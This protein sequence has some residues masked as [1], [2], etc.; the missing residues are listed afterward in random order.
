MH[1]TKNLILEKAMRVGYGARGF[2]YLVIGGLAIFTAFNGGEAEGSTG[3]LNYLVRQPFGSVLVGA[4]ALGLF[5]YALWRFIDAALDLEDEGDDANGLGNRFGQFLSG[6]THA[7]LGVTALTIMI[8]GAQSESDSASNW[9]AAIMSAPFGRW[10]VASA[11]A[12]T[13]GVAVYLFFKAWRASYRAQI[14]CAPTTR[15]LAPLIRFGLAAHGVVLLI[16][17]GMIAYAGWTTDPQHAIGLGEALKIVE[18]RPFGR[19]LLGI[20]GAGMACF[21]IYC[22]VQAGY[23]IA[24]NITHGDIPT[25][26]S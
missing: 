25:L 20:T 22:F 7:F 6:A 12:V 5:S 16:I 15:R 21:S 26:D 2:V 23:R 9:S 24:P 3:A 10:L 11:G 18:T 14:R 4:V 19:T 13:I 17:G 1:E 8:K